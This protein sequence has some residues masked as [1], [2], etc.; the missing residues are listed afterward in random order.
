MPHS[1]FVVVRL[2]HALGHRKMVVHYVFV[3]SPAP[4][5]VSP[6]QVLEDVSQEHARKTVT[7]EA[8]PH[9]PGGVQVGRSRAA[10]AGASAVPGGLGLPA[11]L[12]SIRAVQFSSWCCSPRRRTLPFS[13]CQA[14]S[15]HPCQHANVMKKLAERVAGEE[16]EFSVER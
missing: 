14:A 4:L 10:L 7:M 2:C 5:S 16:E 1:D 6:A 12:R 13:S 8:H 15:I 3:H 9:G 11:G